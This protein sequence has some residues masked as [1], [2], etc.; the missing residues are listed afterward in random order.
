MHR[1]TSALVLT[2]ALSAAAPTMAQDAP[3]LDTVEARVAYGI[4]L[5]IG[6]QLASQGIPDFD[7]DALALAIQDRLDGTAPRLD[8]AEI[9]A[10]FAALSAKAEEQAQARGETA[11]AE[12]N[13]FLDANRDEDGV[14]TTESGLQYKVIEEGSGES[15]AATDSVTVHYEG[16]LLT[17]TVFDSSIARGTPAS[18]PVNGVI[19]GWQEALQLMKPG[20]TWEVWIPSEA[21]YG[22]QGAGQSIGPNEVLN[23]TIELI[24]IDS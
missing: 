19:R 14:I 1:F 13:T 24:S 7:V 15:P 8:D 20:A 4:G 11:L 21:A 22:T 5:Q 9:Q 10:A 16:R 12:G 3:A 6:Q 23:F 17:G 18:F 2:V